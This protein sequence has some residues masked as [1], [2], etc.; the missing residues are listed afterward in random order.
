MGIVGTF[1]IAGD[2][3][4]EDLV[5]LSD[6]QIMFLTGKLVAVT[7]SPSQSASLT[8]PPQGGAEPSAAGGRTSEASEWQRS[9]KSRISVSPTIFPGTATGRAEPSAAAPE[10]NTG[11]GKGAAAPDNHTVGC[12]DSHLCTRGSLTGTASELEGTE[13]EVK[14]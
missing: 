6:E 1:F 5:S 12:A 8:A 11:S 10:R 4:G 2:D 13:Q 9:E 3:G 14:A 7:V